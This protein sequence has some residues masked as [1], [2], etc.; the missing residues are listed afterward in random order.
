[1]NEEIA[2]LVREYQETKSITVACAVCDL[3][4]KLM[5]EGEKNDKEDNSY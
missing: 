5:Q 3:L 4:Y 1:M 2:A